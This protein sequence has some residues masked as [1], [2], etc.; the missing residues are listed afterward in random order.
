MR[1]FVVVF[2]AIAM[3]FAGFLALSQRAVAQAPAGGYLDSIVFF[4]QANP[5]QA[6]SDVS[7]GTNMQLYMF[8]LRNLADIQAALADPNIKTVITPGSVDDMFINPVQ[9]AAGVPGFNVFAIKEVRE[10]MH[11][12]IDRDFIVEQIFGGYGVPYTSPYHPLQPD[13]LRDIVFYNNLDREYAYDPVKAR[14]VVFASL[15]QVTNM[16]FEADGKWYFNGAPLTV[17]MIIRTEDRRLDIGNYVADQI[18]TLGIAVDRQYHPGTSAFNI[19][20]FGP[21]EVGA[22]HIYT[23]GFGFT[24]LT[25]WGDNFIATLGW[26]RSSGEALWDF[27]TPSATL[28]DAAGRLERAQYRDYDERLNLM[29][30][31]AVE[32]MKDPVRLMI[33]A[34]EAVFISNKDVEGYVYDLSGGPWTLYG[35]RTARYTTGTAAAHQNTLRVG[36]PLHWNSQ[37]N[38]YRGFTWLYDETQRRALTDFG[39]FWH[40]HLGVYIP[41]RSAFNVQTSGGYDATPLP[42]PAD[43]VWFNASSAAFEPV[44]AGVGAVSKITY[45]HTFGKVHDGSDMS[46]DDIWWSLSAA[47]RRLNNTFYGGVINPITGEEYPTGDIG[48]A[49]RRAASAAAVTFLS[50]FKGAKQVD[51]DSMEIYLDFWHLDGGEIA[52]I[53]DVFPTLPWHVEM[54]MT[55][56]VLDRETAFHATT[57]TNEGRVRLE[58]I[59]GDSLGY[60]AADLDTLRTANAIPSHLTAQIT[61]AEATARWNALETFS[62]TTSTV[63][64]QAGYTG[65]HFYAS[66]GPYWL[67]T[68]NIAD[69]QTVMNRFVDYPYEANRWDSML[70]PR[71]PAVTIGTIPEVV[72]G[73][74]VTIPVTTTLFGVAYD[75]I[76]LDYLVTNPA[77]GE[78]LFQGN[79]T[80]VAAGSWTISLTAEQTSAILPGTYNVQAVGVGA[81]AAVPAVDTKSFVAIPQ[82]AFF[83]R[84]IGEIQ[85]GLETEIQDAADEA[86][87]ATAA[88][89]AARDEVRSLSGLLTIAVAVSIVAVLVSAVSVVMTL[90]K[91]KG[92]G[93]A[94][95]LEEMPPKADEEL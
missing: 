77:T 7:A 74:A 57:A 14:E 52:A 47:F 5:T 55:Q 24:A 49:D 76:D 94:P 50:A 60:L 21:P 62:T 66:H 91:G 1:K 22:W 44:G 64:G 56:T 54:L 89:N 81:E 30:T 35:A 19:V 48:N 51:A 39:V 6:V 63:T 95:K 46:M 88:A 75:N 78:V 80:R 34:E 86:A 61:S 4:E 69:R 67:N 36:Q 53:G 59:R 25:A 16:T 82:L 93:G 87:A 45:D 32:A 23:E 68:V 27:Y 72:P 90:R 20:Y 58:L 31:A 10:A 40:P 18:E 9:H 70:V 79:P 13:Y 73:L 15:S 33:V 71:V 92:A 83:E 3:L 41:I 17:V 85:A 37:W 26:T 28:V 12:L 2:V 8:N 38:P 29:R 42:V 43:A 84:L 11:W 65:G